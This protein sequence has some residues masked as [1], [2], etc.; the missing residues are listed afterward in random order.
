MSEKNLIFKIN[1]IPSD[2]RSIILS[3]LDVLNGSKFS[4]CF[5]TVYEEWRSV[6]EKRWNYFQK[7][8]PVSNSINK[9]VEDKKCYAKAIHC[10]FENNKEE[11]LIIGG[12]LGGK[13]NNNVTRMIIDNKNNINFEV[14]PPLLLASYWQDALYHEGEIYSINRY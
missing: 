8:N 5:K 4:M 9:Y 13:S 7:N 6:P 10:Y 1:S 14:K 11:V 3:Y 2:T 12:S